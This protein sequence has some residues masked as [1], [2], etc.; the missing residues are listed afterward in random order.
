MSETRG[1]PESQ[2]K[3][4]QTNLDH[5]SETR[6]QPESQPKLEQTNLD[7]MS[8]TRGQPEPQ[9]KLEPE[10]EPKL[11]P[12][13]VPEPETVQPADMVDAQI[14][15]IQMLR[16]LKQEIGSLKQDVFQVKVVQVAATT[17]YEQL[18]EQVR[19]ESKRLGQGRELVTDSADGE[20]L[21]VIATELE[22]TTFKLHETIG[23]E[24]ETRERLDALE[25]MMQESS[26]E[27]E[28][29]ERLDAL[30]TMMQES[31]KEQETRE[32]LD[33]LETMMQ[34][35]SKEQETCERLD[36][37]ETMMQESSK[38]QETCERLDALET[39]IEETA[40]V[41]FVTDAEV[42]S[43]RSHI[44]QDAEVR[45]RTLIART[46][47]Q[48]QRYSALQTKR[49]TMGAWRRRVSRKLR[50]QRV[51]AKGLQLMEHH[52][53]RKLF[54]PWLSAARQD[55]HDRREVADEAQRLSIDATKTQVHALS[56]RMRRGS[57]ISE[58]Q[59][60][61][62][63]QDID[64]IAVAE[65][66]KR[67]AE[68][69]RRAQDKQLRLQRMQR[70]AIA[71]MEQL[72]VANAFT[73][74]L[75]AARSLRSR[76]HHEVIETLAEK[77]ALL[78]AS[79]P[80]RGHPAQVA[81]ATERAKHAACEVHMGHN[82]RAWLSAARS[83]QCR[84]TREEVEALQEELA[85]QVAHNAEKHGELCLA[86]ETLEDESGQ[87]V[88]LAT[89]E[90]EV[91][92]PN[93]VQ[94]LMVEM[95]QMKQ[96]HETEVPLPNEVQQLMVEMAQMKQDRETEMATMNDVMHALGEKLDGLQI[97]QAALQKKREDA[98]QAALQNL[99][100]LAEVAAEAKQAS[101]LESSSSDDG[102]APPQDDEDS[103]EASSPKLTLA[104]LHAE[105]VAMNQE[106]QRQHQDAAAQRQVEMATMNDALQALDEQS[107]ST[108]TQLRQTV[109]ALAAQQE[110]PG[111]PRRTDSLNSEASAD[112]GEM[113]EQITQELH[114]L[115]HLSFD[116]VQQ[117]EA[118]A[119]QA[120]QLMV[121]LEQLRRV[122]HEA[123]Q[124]YA[125][126]VLCLPRV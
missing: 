99:D 54:L 79:M 109:D 122:S 19:G 93:E 8:E 32:R 78:H 9:P 46:V 14:N 22:D 13:P 65:E 31:S 95:A 66:A 120:E 45:R 7:R 84:Q 74:W 83:L 15:A 21:E 30:Q 114:Q 41:S 5:M 25:T 101:Q 98:E 35:S 112:G 50:T 88:E 3:L 87:I 61:K 85:L 43:L 86:M 117:K 113:V 53:I 60:A 91:P 44:I 20:A 68:N 6:G 12:E 121:E 34:E 81:A 126:P 92:L 26:K 105:M 103:D 4:E 33:A 75:V 94:Q 124:T 102:G 100:R 111:G 38:E 125:V 71:R 56:E 40:G 51:R 118:S 58:D 123:D 82:F 52:S 24:Q 106:L 90:P 49:D 97:E 1:Q 16:L 73:P 28:T 70:K 76:Q 11:E 115:R 107:S 17:K 110:A 37:L 69:A 59:V 104:T 10:P 2:P 29:R 18:A 67:Q 119:E 48:A 116:A 23:K 72:S 39:M 108:V 62:M 55:R 89:R 96:D 77:I 63:A 42:K 57:A 27:Q 47:Q 36:A 64:S 80:R